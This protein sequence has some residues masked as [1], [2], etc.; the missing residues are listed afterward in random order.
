MLVSTLIALALA[1]IL[2]AFAKNI[3]SSQSLLMP[4]IIATMIPFMVSMFFDISTLPGAAR[5]ILYAIPFTH[6]FMSSDNVIFG[7]TSLY[8]GGLIYQLVFL[9]IC[10]I[11]A[12]KIYT[13]D[14]IFTAS[15]FRFGKKKKRSKENEV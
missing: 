8:V 10:M 14:M 11:I 9:A 7:K 12:V 6:T 15:E 4:V 3:K 5:Y 1:M 2:G 13:S